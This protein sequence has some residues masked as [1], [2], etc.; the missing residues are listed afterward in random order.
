LAKNGNLSITIKALHNFYEFH[1]I[2]ESWF[3][4]PRILFP[5]ETESINQILKDRGVYVQ[6][7]LADNDLLIS[8]IMELCKVFIFNRLPEELIIKETLPEPAFDLAPSFC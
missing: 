5:K 8:R 3:E 1:R 2:P 6:V 4:V 7:S